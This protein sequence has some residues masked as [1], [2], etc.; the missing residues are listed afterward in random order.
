MPVKSG[1]D[2]IKLLNVAFEARYSE[3]FRVLDHGGKTLVAL[4]KSHPLWTVRNAGAVS[5]LQHQDLPFT[6]KFDAQS[7]AITV[8]GANWE[9]PQASGSQKVVEQLASEA[10]VLYELIVGELS[11]PDTTRVGV[12]FTFGAP[13]DSAEASDRFVCK[14]LQGEFVS[15]LETMTSSQFID[16]ECKFTLEDE[17]GYRRHFRIFSLA[18]QPS[19]FS[20]IRHGFPDP[21]VAGFVAFELDTFTR[22]PSGHF[23]NVRRFIND[24]F[25]KSSSYSRKWFESA[26]QKQRKSG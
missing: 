18:Q 17:F 24:Q 11:V 19:Q 12:L 1:Q 20:P 4:Q 13:S 3:G 23:A 6:A 7:F 9:S 26:R 16:S 8:S 5:K 10:E 25:A 2:D 21:D 15:E 14:S 22:P